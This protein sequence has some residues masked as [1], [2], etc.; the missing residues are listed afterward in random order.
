MHQMTN[1]Q[2]FDDL[3]RKI[4]KGDVIALRAWIDANGDVNLRNKFGWTLLMMAALHGRTD[5][6]EILLAAGADAKASN[7][8]GDTAVSLARLK[9]FNRTAETIERQSRSV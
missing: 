4:K 2:V 6:V 1:D 7:K 9:G 3:H 5:M 8:H